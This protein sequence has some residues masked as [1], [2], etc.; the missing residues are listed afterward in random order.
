[1]NAPSFEL[2][3]TQAQQSCAGHWIKERIRFGGRSFA[4]SAVRGGG[5]ARREQSLRYRRHRGN[6]GQAL[7]DHDGRESKRRG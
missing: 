5:N 3:E 6:D 2:S 1:M 7:N 4:Q